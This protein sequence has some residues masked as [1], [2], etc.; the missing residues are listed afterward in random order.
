MLFPFKVIIFQSGPVTLKM[1]YVTGCKLKMT[2]LTSNMSQEGMLDGR[3][4][5]QI[6]TMVWLSIL[7]IFL[8]HILKLTCHKIFIRYIVCLFVCLFIYL[9][10]QGGFFGSY[11]ADVGLRPTASFP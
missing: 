1:A 4:I 11:A 3:I 10:T 8:I 5:Q 6:V 9:L 7:L 2:N